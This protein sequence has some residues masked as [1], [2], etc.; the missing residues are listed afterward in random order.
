MI[1]SEKLDVYPFLDYHYAYSLGNYVKEMIV[2][3]LSGESCMAAKFSGMD[4]R[5]VL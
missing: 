2:K 5:E 1:V 3:V 4:D